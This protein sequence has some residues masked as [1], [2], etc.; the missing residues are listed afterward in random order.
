MKDCPKCGVE[1]SKSGVF[2]SRK[3]ANSRQWSD[4]DREKKSASCKGRIP[5][6]K[7]KTIGSNPVKN[8]KLSDTLRSK[9]RERFENGEIFTRSTLKA[10]II[11]R[12]GGYYCQ[13][14]ELTEWRG[15]PISLQVDHIDG[16]ATNN[17]PENLRLICPNCHSQTETF[18]GKNR[19]NGRKSLGVRT[20]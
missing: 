18:G 14:C 9:H 3:C 19:G 13:V 6:H 2:C 4:A 8:A 15:K 12:A 1:H 7:G 10:Y 16:C 17:T 11:E 5:W 20:F